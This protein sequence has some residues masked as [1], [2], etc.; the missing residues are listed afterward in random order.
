MFSTNSNGP[1]P[2]GTAVGAST[3]PRI[4]R[5]GGTE[6]VVHRSDRPYVLGYN[7]RRPHLDNPRFRNTL[8]RLIDER[9]LGDDILDGYAHTAVGPLNETEW[10]PDSL[11]WDEGNPVVPFLGEDGELN[12]SAARD[13][14]REAGYQYEEGTLLGRNT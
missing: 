2:T 3:V 10:Y 6:L 14:F 11:T 8:A 4:G 7:T 9:F 1:L 12:A 13:A 5:A